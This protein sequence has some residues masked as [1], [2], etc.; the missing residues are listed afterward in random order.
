MSAAPNRPP[1]P[2]W[3]LIQRVDPARRA[4]PPASSAPAA[5]PDSCCSAR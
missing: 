5:R 3:L 2:P 1:A 4:W